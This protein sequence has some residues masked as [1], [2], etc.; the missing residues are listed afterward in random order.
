M[1]VSDWAE[2][3]EEEMETGFTAFGQPICYVTEHYGTIIARPLEAHHPKGSLGP[4]WGGSFVF[5][6]DSRFSEMTGT[7]LPLKL[8]DRYETQHLYDSLSQ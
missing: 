6:S 7:Y 8:M 1:L 4:M 3:S 2:C 5:S